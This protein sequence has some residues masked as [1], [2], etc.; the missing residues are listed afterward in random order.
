VATIT[1]TKSDQH[2]Y[3]LHSANWLK[4]QRTSNNNNNN[5]WST[6]QN[7]K[8]LPHH[9][10]S[11]WWLMAERNDDDN[12][13]YMIE[14]DDDDHYSSPPAKRIKLGK[15][16]LRLIKSINDTRSDRYI[17]MWLP[18]L[19]SFSWESIGWTKRKKTDMRV[20]LSYKCFHWHFYIQIWAWHAHIPTDDW[21]FLLSFFFLC[22]FLFIHFLDRKK[23][24]K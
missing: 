10:E 14:E 12:L 2:Y 21:F 4:E 22:I 6:F 17:D 20:F 1:H 11:T 24:F 13:N 5:H 18:L 23:T 16:F 19:N 3:L 7:L 8:T 9:F 15:W